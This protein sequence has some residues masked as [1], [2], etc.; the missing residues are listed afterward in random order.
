MPDH[1]LEGEATFSLLRL[2]AIDKEERWL[3]EVKKSFEYFMKNDY[4]NH[5]DHWLSYAVNEL[6]IYEPK[7]EYFQFGLKNCFGRLDFIY[8]RDTTY[9]TFLEL[10]MAA[11][12]M[13]KKM[14]ELGKED[15]LEGYDY[16]FLV[17][18]IDHR[19]EYQRTG[20]FYPEVAMYMKQPGL[21][22]HGFFIRHHSLR[23]RI[24]DV[25]HYLSGYCQY[26]KHRTPQLSENYV[27]SLEGIK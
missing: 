25:E 20:F 24:D 19:A 6:A 23:V 18:T 27:S 26:K 15:L 2:Y 11:Y 3:D 16:N 14:K 5:H 4:W 7:D 12:Q 10:S 8:H 9:P 13:V 22:L 17:A 1:R 21:I